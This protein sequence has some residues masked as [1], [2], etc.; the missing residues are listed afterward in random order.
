MGSVLGAYMEGRLFI[1]ALGRCLI[2]E[3]LLSNEELAGIT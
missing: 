2:L 1:L 3:F